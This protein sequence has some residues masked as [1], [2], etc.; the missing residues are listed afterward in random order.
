MTM[1]TIKGRGWANRWV[2]YWDGY[3]TG[4]AA[5]LRASAPPNEEGWFTQEEREANVPTWRH[6][7]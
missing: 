5:A 3:R 6:L 4:Y 2:A 1:M 7:S